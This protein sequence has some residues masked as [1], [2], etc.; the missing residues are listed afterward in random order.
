MR[1]DEP[2]ACAIIVGPAG[3]GWAWELISE[4]GSIA[5]RGAA[6]RQEA[7]L[8]SA[9]NAAGLLAA[10]AQDRA[11]FSARAGGAQAWRG[12]TRRAR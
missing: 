3:A 10:Q 7:A 11:A 6:D 9:Q 4:D 2:E 1:G 5:A 8:R 12:A